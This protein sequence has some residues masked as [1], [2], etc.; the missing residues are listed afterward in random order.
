VGAATR[1]SAGVPIR[2]AAKSLAAA[3]A[4]NPVPVFVAAAADAVVGAAEGLQF[5]PRAAVAA[6]SD[7]WRLPP[8]A[9][10]THA[11]DKMRQGKCQACAFTRTAQQGLHVG[12]ILSS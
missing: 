5:G 8:R 11:N 4:E 10:S 9:A 1:E 12:D 7:D 6:R 2:A 3:P